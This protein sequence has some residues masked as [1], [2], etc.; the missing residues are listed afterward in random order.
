MKAELSNMWKGIAIPQAEQ[1]TVSVIYKL[2]VSFFYY[3]T[4]LQEKKHILLGCNKWSPPPI[5]VLG[6]KLV[7]GIF[8]IF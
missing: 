8:R 1:E 6:E 4:F 5:T 2:Y 7:L 3:L